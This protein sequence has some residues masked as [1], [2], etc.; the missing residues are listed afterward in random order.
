MKSIIFAVIGIIL[1]L[2]ACSQAGPATTIGREVMVEG[3]SYRDITPAQL[4]DM[5]DSKDFLFVNVHIPYEGEIPGTDV[6][7]PYNKVEENLSS[8][9]DD[10]AAK[11]VLYCRSDSMSGIAARTLV[12]LGFTNIWNLDGGF[13][14]WERQ[15]YEF[16]RNGP[17][18]GQPR[19]SF[20]EESADIG[21]VPMGPPSGYTFR[22]R[23]VGDGTL[24]ILDTGLVALEGC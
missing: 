1:L 3:G 13:V 19:I 22:F 7:L 17:S 16:I 24:E 14:E 18:A 12:G 9:P 20:E 11:I 2:A 10:R 5:F 15:G 4:K 21:I 8:L 23:N 6:F